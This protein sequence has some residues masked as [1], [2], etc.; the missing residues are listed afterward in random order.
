MKG[1]ACYSREFTER[2]RERGRQPTCMLCL[3][4]L[5]LSQDEKLWLLICYKFHPV[6]SQIFQGRPRAIVSHSNN[7]KKISK[8][9]MNK[10]INFTKIFNFNTCCFR[11]SFRKLEH[12]CVCVCVRVMWLNYSNG[13]GFL[14]S[15]EC[16]NLTELQFL[17]SMR[18]KR[19]IELLDNFEC[20]VIN[21]QEFVSFAVV[22]AVDIVVV[23]VIINLK[24]S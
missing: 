12:V 22:V 7:N 3:L 1:T 20:A 5:P 11:E 24:C 2:E 10:V 13:K 6:H 16:V 19:V 17:C 23:W 15:A 4:V 21:G 9:F 18:T 14:L 8:L